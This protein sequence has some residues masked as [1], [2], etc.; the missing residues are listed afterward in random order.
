MPVRIAELVQPPVPALSP[1]V[2]RLSKPVLSAVEG[3]ER[4]FAA[5]EDPWFESLTTNG[6]WNPSDAGAGG[7]PIG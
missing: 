4:G 2:L 3:D 1:F 5:P 6:T 7:Q